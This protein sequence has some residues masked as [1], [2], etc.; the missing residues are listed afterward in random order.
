M[1]PQ[2]F[3]LIALREELLSLGHDY[4]AIMHCAARHGFCATFTPATHGGEPALC[5]G[6]W[7]GVPADHSR[8]DGHRAAAAVIYCS[9]NRA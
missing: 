4:E 8:C 1:T 6:I 5:M 3:D 2:G 9:W 7:T